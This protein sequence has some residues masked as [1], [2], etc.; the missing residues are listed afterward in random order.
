MKKQ[1]VLILSHFYNDS[2]VGLFNRL[3]QETPDSYDIFIALNL[4]E[5]K[6]ELPENAESLRKSIFLLNNERILE[7]PYPGKCDPGGWNGKGFS[8]EGH[9]DLITLLFQQEHPEY[10]YYWGIEY[11]VHFE[12]K[13]GEL[14]NHFLESKADLLGTSLMRA[15]N[16]P[17]LYL[18]TLHPR[19]PYC[20]E[21]GKKPSYQESIMGFFPIHR[22]SRLL[23]ERLDE[24]YRA[25]WNGYYE[26]T[27]AT[28]ADK[29]HLLIEDIGGN[30]PYVK[31]ENINRFYYNTARR[32]DYTPGTFVYRPTFRVIDQRIKNT[33]WHPVKPKGNYEFM[34]SDKPLGGVLVWTKHYI[35]RIW[36]RYTMH[37]WA[38]EKLNHQKNQYEA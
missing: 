17:P 25:G 20:D 11:D 35:K 30:G 37:R 15:S 14:F 38:K 8:I 2:I 26:I 34:G 28:I 29:C 22:L 31:P 27:W 1:A 21:N 32:W 12:G 23:C 33:L 9:A 18:K 24:Y 6:L 5:K 36:C 19:N 13:W 7:M 3:T 16:K 10:E 4:G